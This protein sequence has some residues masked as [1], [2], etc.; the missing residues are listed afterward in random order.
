MKAAVRVRTTVYLRPAAM[1]SLRIRAALTDRTISS[2][3]EEAVVLAT[4]EEE[5]DAR[6]VRS[7]AAEPS[8]PFDAVVRDL[9]RDGLL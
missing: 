5:I 6:A 9:R 1:R 3:V 8:R 7:R 4:K 2:L